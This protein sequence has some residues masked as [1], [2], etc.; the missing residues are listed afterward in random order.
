MVRILLIDDS[1]F[2]YNMIA[3]ILE[4]EI[5]NITSVDTATDAFKYLEDNNPDL[6][7]LSMVLPDMDG[8]S[9]C[10]KL[11]QMPNFKGVPI[12]FVSSNDDE[13]SILRGFE[14]GAADYIIKPFSTAEFKARVTCQIQNKLMADKLRLTNQKL[15]NMMEELKFQ[16]YKDPVTNC[17][18]RKYFLEHVESWKMRQTRD[19]Y[20]AFLYMID[21]DDF[22]NINDTYGHSTGDYALITIAELIRNEILEDSAVIRWGGDEFLL[23]V[24]HINTASATEIGEKL[25]K[26][27][28]DY[29]FSFD[30]NRFS[31]SLTIGFTEFF[32]ELKIEDQICLADKALY[33]GKQMG[34]NICID[35]SNMKNQSI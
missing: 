4:T 25:R 3:K 15:V 13:E 6:I 29:P 31:C 12:V 28:N 33:F 32:S 17:Y 22:K 2:I 9:L 23:M 30:G 8:H 35:A 10:K 1:I 11:K 18:N 34:R 26:L 20:K 19:N 14:A 5:V 21:I 16:S 24:F 27:V 7:L